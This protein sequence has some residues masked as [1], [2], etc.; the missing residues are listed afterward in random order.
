VIRLFGE[1]IFITKLPNHRITVSPHIWPNPKA[2]LYVT[3]VDDP[4]HNGLAN[5]LLAANGTRA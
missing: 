4:L 5:A 1:L 3:I 2:Y